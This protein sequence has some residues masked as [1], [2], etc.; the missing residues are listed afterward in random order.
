[1]RLGG[2]GGY[3]TIGAWEARTASGIQSQNA[4][5][6]RK[7]PPGTMGRGYKSPEQIGSS[8]R[9]GLIQRF[10]LVREV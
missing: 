5:I 3:K 4:E 1:V 6:K 8:N 2:G 7:K 10:F 9:I